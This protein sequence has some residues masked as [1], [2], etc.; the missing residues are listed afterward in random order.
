MDLD[1]IKQDKI[2][3]AEKLYKK[4][5]LENHMEYPDPKDMLKQSP[6]PQENQFKDQKFHWTRLSINSNFGCI[7]E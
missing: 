4:I 7:V 2:K 5:G 3:E 1:K 6:L